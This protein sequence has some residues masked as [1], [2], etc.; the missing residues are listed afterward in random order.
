MSEFNPN[1]PFEEGEVTV[2]SY[3]GVRGTRVDSDLGNMEGS[4]LE[5]DRTGTVN[6]RWVNPGGVINKGVWLEGYPSYR[7]PS[8]GDTKEDINEAIYKTVTGKLLG[9]GDYSTWSK[10]FIG[11]GCVYVDGIAL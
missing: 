6:V 2:Y 1:V 10:Q 3:D 7:G 9:H 5:G 11:T 4:S 8:A